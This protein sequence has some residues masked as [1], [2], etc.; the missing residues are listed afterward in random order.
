M[1]ELGEGLC[2]MHSQGEIPFSAE[3]PGAPG[4]LSPRSLRPGVRLP[5]RDP[6]PLPG[7]AF[8]KPL[9]E[10]SSA[11]AD[12]VV[13]V[14]GWFLLWYFFQHLVGPAQR[15]GFLRLADAPL[16]AV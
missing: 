2:F 3:R 11:Q 9:L 15:A 1:A 12:P 10:N 13:G 5:R 14:F 8:P 16:I 7:L 4:R 6:V